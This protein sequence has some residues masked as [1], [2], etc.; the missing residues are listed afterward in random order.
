MLIAV[1]CQSFHSCLQW[2]HKKGLHEEIEQYYEPSKFVHILLRKILTQNVEIDIISYKDIS[3][4]SKLGKSQG[5]KATGLKHF[6]HDS[7]VADE[8]TE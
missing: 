7:R 8:V 6:C 5:R 2:G 1:I 4:H 3:D